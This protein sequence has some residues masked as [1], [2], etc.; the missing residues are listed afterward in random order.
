MIPNNV[1]R[2]SE[3]WLARECNDKCK[4]KFCKESVDDNDS[5]DE[6]SSPDKKSASAFSIDGK[7]SSASLFAACPTTTMDEGMGVAS[8]FVEDDDKPYKDELAECLKLDKIANK[9]DFVGIQ[10]WRDNKNKFPNLSVMARQCLGTP[11]TS[12]TVERL[13]SHVG[14]VCAKARKSLKPKTVQDIAFAKMNTE[15]K[16][17]TEQAHNDLIN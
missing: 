10:W 4:D 1:K 15:L 6:P 9:N 2:K 7:A 11:A 16:D 17:Q 8:L 14:F 12:A 3:Q 5:D 13:F